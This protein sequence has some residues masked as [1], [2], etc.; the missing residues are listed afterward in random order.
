MEEGFSTSGLT[1]KLWFIFRASHK[2]LANW[3]LRFHKAKS[4][5][6]KAPSIST[7]SRTTKKRR[8]ESTMPVSHA[9]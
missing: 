2:F 7:Q 5:V 1:G 3:I 9:T 8:N 4:T 6:G